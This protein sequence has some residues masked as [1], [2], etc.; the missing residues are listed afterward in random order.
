MILI[1]TATL[2]GKPIQRYLGLVDGEALLNAAIT[3]ELF[4]Y[5]KELRRSKARALTEM[6]QKAQEM[7]ANTIVGVAVEYQT[8]PLEGEGSILLIGA[9]GTAVFLKESAP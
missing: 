6:Q 2:E 7:G 5:E 9:S 3:E 4:L 1:T 8:I